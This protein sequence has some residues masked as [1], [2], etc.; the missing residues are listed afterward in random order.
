[1]LQRQETALQGVVTDIFAH[2]FVVQLDGKRVLADLTPKGAER[3]SLKTGDKVEL[4][5]EAK[6]SEIKVQRISVGGRGAIEIPHGPPKHDHQDVS[7]DAALAGV[8]RAGFKAVGE[9]RRKPK[10]FEILARDAHGKH[11]ELH[12]EFDGHLRKSK[13]ADSEKWSEE[14]RRAERV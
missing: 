12:V 13:E 8:A 2:R 9:P 6:P 1:M 3:I 11:L 5:G 10:H 14:L 7:S 4:W